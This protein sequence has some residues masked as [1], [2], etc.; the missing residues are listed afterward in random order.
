MRPRVIGTFINVIYCYR[1]SIF[2]LLTLISPPWARGDCAPPRTPLMDPWGQKCFFKLVFLSYHPHFIFFCMFFTVCWWKHQPQKNPP[3]L[4]YIFSWSTYLGDSKKVKTKIPLY[5]S[6][7]ILAIF[8]GILSWDFA[9]LMISG[10]Q[11]REKYE[12][13]FCEK[14]D[15]FTEIF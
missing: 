13:N 14:I 12:E 9:C 15:R 2:G 1:F 8:F 11:W 4:R 7:E 6:S 10:C 5:P 3:S